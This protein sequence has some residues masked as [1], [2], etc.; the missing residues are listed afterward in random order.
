MENVVG[1]NPRGEEARSCP[2]DATSGN[3][4]NLGFSVS[5]IAVWEE[6]VGDSEGGDLLESALTGVTDSSSGLAIRRPPRDCDRLKSPFMAMDSPLYGLLGKRVTVKD[7]QSR[8][9]V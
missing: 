1:S 4:G 7:R 8:I 5:F 3:V 6:D 2:L 9:L